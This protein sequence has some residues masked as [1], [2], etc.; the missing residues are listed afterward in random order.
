MKE[1]AVSVKEKLDGL[2]INIK[3]KANGT[4]LYASLSTDDLIKEL[5]ELVKIRLTKSNF[6]ANLHLKDIGTH[7]VEIKLAQ[8]LKAVLKVNIV[9]DPT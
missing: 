4:K 2:K 5:V 9:A 8:G 7:D 3:G 6:P 1:D